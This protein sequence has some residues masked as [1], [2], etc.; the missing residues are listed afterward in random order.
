MA[1]IIIFGIEDF[2][3]LAHYYLDNDSNHEVV[4]FS[5]NQKYLPEIKTFRGLP[6][7]EFE[8]IENVNSP[9]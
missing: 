1:R 4:A 3:E 7:I 6:I 2:A 9:N 8:N 5:V